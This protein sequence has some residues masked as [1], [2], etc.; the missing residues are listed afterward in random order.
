MEKKRLFIEIEKCED[1]LSDK[2]LTTIQRNSILTYLESLNKE[3]S[4][5]IKNE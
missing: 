4:M 3:K 5:G 2:T 1:I